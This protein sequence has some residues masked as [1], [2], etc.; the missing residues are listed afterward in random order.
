[1]SG[2]AST[3]EAA[4]RARPPSLGATFDPRLN[5]LNLLRVV[6]ALGVVLWHSFQLTGARI[7][8][9][10]A[11]ILMLSGFVDGFFAISGFLIVRSWD[12]RPDARRFLRARVLRIMPGFWVCLTVVA[13][14]LGPAAAIIQQA[15]M[16]RSFVE[17]ELSYVGKNSLLWMFQARIAGTPEA[18]PWNGSAW[19]LSWEFAC[20]LGVL[21]L[22]LAGILLRRSVLPALFATAL[23]VLVLTGLPA[24]DI[25]ILH[26]AA[27]FA[28]MFLAGSVIYVVRDR[29]PARAAWVAGSLVLVIVATYLP[30]YRLL[31]ALPLAY[32]C[33]VSGALIKVPGLQLRTDLSY[34]MYIY[35][36]PV[37]QLLRTAGLAGKGVPLYF[38]L[39][40]LA[41]LPLAAL[42][43]F[44]VERPAQ[45]WGRRS[46]PLVAD[47]P[48]EA[49]AAAPP[50]RLDPIR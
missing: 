9:A 48:E 47:P 4:D 41:T 16:G 32:A 17:D 1:M 36:F 15:P 28:T 33:V 5:G 22:G 8:W 11:R 35:A 7:G 31:G 12:L 37:Q 42:S 18:G 39:S 19:T 26:H 45:R 44:G 50:R 43:W 6:L 40:V 21:G 29:L 24:F 10:P 3:A 27:R 14:V 20:Y 46:R 38:A 30:D 23:A 49:V 25:G 2:A 34:G 13:F